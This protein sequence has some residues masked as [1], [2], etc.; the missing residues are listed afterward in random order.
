MPE[1]I[2]NKSMIL[3][4]YNLNEAKEYLEIFNIPLSKVLS[5]PYTW[6]YAYNLYMILPLEPVNSMNLYS[7]QKVIQKLRNAFNVNNIIGTRYIITNR[8][9]K[10]PRYIRNFP[11]LARS[12]RALITE[13]HWEVI[14]PIYESVEQTA[15][16][17]ATFK[18]WVAP[19]GSMLMNMIYMNFNKT[20]GLCMICSDCV[21]Y[22]NC[23]LAVTLDI[24]TI[25]FTNKFLHHVIGGGCC[26]V[27][28]GL[29]CVRRI[30]YAVK[31]GKWP[32]DYKN[33]MF[34][35]FDLNET[36]KIMNNNVSTLVQV[37]S[38]NGSYVYYTESF[39]YF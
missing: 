4:P 23:G 13:V 10:N 29:T 33:D 3:I 39:V 12:I 5:Y 28:Y 11:I 20:T 27:S 16:T 17:V 37:K 22:P 8:R 14:K 36:K 1:D 2:I 24:W 25:S 21:D 15:K 6:Y 7:F 35:A 32:D 38:I 34:H 26:D 18:V 9:P 19:S 30:L 31:Y